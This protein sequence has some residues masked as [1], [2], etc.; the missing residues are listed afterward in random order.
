MWVP[1]SRERTSGRVASSGV[2]QTFGSPVTD[3]ITWEPRGL[4]NPNRGGHPNDPKS[5]RPQQTEYSN[6]RTLQGADKYEA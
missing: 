1:A 3:S 2:R 4:Q 5:R 6:L